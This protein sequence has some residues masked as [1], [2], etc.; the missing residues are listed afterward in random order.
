M[1]SEELIAE[2]EAEIGYVFKNKS[3]LIQALTHPSA[4]M[5][6]ADRNAHYQRLEFLGDS[7]LSFIMSEQL[8]FYYPEE[9]EGILAS[10][11]TILTQGTFQA[12]LA[13]TLNLQKYII[14]SEAEL[15]AR[16]QFRPSIL[17]DVFESLIA[18]IFL[19][20]DLDSTKKVIL[21]FY[22]NIPELLN[23]LKPTQNPKGQLQEWLHRKKPDSE[24]T[25]TIVGTTG[26]DHDKR[27]IV[28]VSIDDVEIALA[29]GVS[30]KT[31][32]AEAAAKA[33]EI[34]MNIP[35]IE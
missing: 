19:D 31:A 7:I 18:A 12:D 26:P 14:L 4:T 1:L 17:E 28:S 25:Y 32:A 13:R 15:N 35:E 22:K 27:F 16:G 21:S 2:L 6:A 34:L 29:E 8:F 30:K 11:R 33:L 3:Y 23:T 5:Y 10:Y 20:S 24:L 9:R